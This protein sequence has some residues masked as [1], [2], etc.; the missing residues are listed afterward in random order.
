[1]TFRAAWKLCWFL[2]EIGIVAVDYFFTTAFVS[3][4]NKRP[5]PGELAQ[6][7]G[8]AAYQNLQL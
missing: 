6:P 8:P 5:R 1:M 7:C 2:L 4:Q 3:K